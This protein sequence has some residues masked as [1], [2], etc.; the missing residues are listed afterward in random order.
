MHVENAK[1]IQL[2][3]GSHV[4]GAIP[5]LC[6]VCPS[7]RELCKPICELEGA[8]FEHICLISIHCWP[9][10]LLL[11]GKVTMASI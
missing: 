5:G 4:H 9:Y 8:P 1:E 10:I 6:K 3:D 11:L 2:N 7:L